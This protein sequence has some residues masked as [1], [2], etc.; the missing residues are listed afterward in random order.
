MCIF[1]L[2]TIKNIFN[3]FLYCT[4][5]DNG[6]NRGFIDIKGSIFINILNTAIHIERLIFTNV[7]YENRIVNFEINSQNSCFINCTA[8][9]ASS[10]GGAIYIDL[11][12]GSINLISTV[13]SH[14]ISTGH[15]G[16]I[17]SNGDSIKLNSCIFYECRSGETGMVVMY[18]FYKFDGSI[19]FRILISQTQFSNNEGK[20]DLLDLGCDEIECTCSNFSYNKNYKHIQ[21]SSPI[22]Y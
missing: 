13:F 18:N 15:G 20:H 14:C 10:N 9:G 5:N 11:S 1:N 19:Y 22:Q 3:S 8:T 7:I 4:T 17:S 16:A 2:I 12:Y 6:Q 21:P